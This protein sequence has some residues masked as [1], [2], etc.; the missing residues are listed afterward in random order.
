MGRQHPFDLTAD[1]V[2]GADFG[3]PGLPLALRTLYG[4]VEKGLD[5]LPARARGHGFLAFS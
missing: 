1:L 2:V 4:F 3:E 5:L